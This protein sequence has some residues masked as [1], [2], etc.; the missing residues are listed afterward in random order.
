M[1]NNVS[2]LIELNLLDSTTGKFIAISGCNGQNRI[3]IHMPFYSFRFLDELNSQKPLYDPHIYKSPDDPIFSDPVYIEE[4]GFIS[5]DT[6]EQRIEKY[7]RRYNISPNYYDENA[8]DFS[9]KGV[10]YINFTGDTNFIE[11]SST[12]L[13]RFSNFIIK[14]NATYHPNGRFY[15]LLR[16]RIIKYLPNFINSLGSLVLIVAFC[17]Y[18]FLTIIFLC[19][20]SRLQEKEI[21]LNS[22]KEEIIKNFYPYAKNIEAIYKKLVPTQMNIKDFKPEIKFGPEANTNIITNTKKI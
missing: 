11:F 1:E 12:H 5:D 2:P 13:C 8:Y 21:L 17:I 6:I 16:P 7:S 20:D 9:L 14:N 19:Y 22:I 15:Y 3:I 18:L 10:D 4:N